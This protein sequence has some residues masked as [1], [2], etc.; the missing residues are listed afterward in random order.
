MSLSTL[1]HVPPTARILPSSIAITSPHQSVVLKV[2]WTL[3][4]PPNELSMRPPAVIRMSDM[5]PPPGVDPHSTTLSSDC[6]SIA[7]AVSLPATNEISLRPF[8]LN[9]LSGVP[10]AS[11]RAAAMF[12]LPPSV[13][14]PSTMRPSSM[15][16]MSSATSA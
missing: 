7:H 15:T 14:P 8:V 9:E 2:G 5:R 12:W 13:L 11:R 1:S 10:S 6:T 16:A 3:P 4:V